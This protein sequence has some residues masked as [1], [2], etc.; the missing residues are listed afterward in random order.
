[1][2]VQVLKLLALALQEADSQSFAGHFPYS[3]R[4][5][6]LQSKTFWWEG[7]AIVE[8]REKVK[9]VSEIKNPFEQ[10]NSMMR[11]WKMVM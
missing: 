9:E 10:D 7:S 6:G 8:R 3:S 4:S 1:M 11:E 2:R 5:S